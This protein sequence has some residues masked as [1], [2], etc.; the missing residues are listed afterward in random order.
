MNVT[1]L[2]ELITK[3]C[4]DAEVAAENGSKV[5]EAIYVVG[6]RLISALKVV[7]IDLEEAI[8]RP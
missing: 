1:R 2:D 8:R 3:N 4:Y 7:A 5:Q 6:A